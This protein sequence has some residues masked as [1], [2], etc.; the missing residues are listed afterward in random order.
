LYIENVVRFFRRERGGSFLPLHSCG[1]CS[2]KAA[3]LPERPERE[4]DRR[5]VSPVCS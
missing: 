4:R 3:A 2:G 1:E 5:R